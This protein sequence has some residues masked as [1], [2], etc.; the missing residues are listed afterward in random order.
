[1][2][3]IHY[4]EAHEHRQD[5]RIKVILVPAGDAADHS[6][7]HSH[8]QFVGRHLRERLLAQ[9]GTLIP[10]HRNVTE[11]KKK[12]KKHFCD[13]AQNSVQNRRVKEVLQIVKMGVS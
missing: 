4:H 12:K 8:S 5:F 2:L 1:M 7:Q 6:A 10:Q 3:S 11:R 13:T 9:E